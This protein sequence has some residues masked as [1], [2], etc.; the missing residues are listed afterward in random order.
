LPQIIKSLAP[1]AGVLGDARIYSF[2]GANGNNGNGVSSA[3]DIN[4]LLLSTSGLSLINTLLEEGKLGN[5]VNQIKDVLK[6]KAGDSSRSESDFPTHTNTGDDKR[7]TASTPQEE[8]ATSEEE[9]FSDLSELDDEE[10]N[11]QNWNQMS[12][13]Q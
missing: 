1:Q 7:E 5:V 9:T 12:G 11:M 3:N 2:P 8:I 10:E 13:N 6:S 4:K